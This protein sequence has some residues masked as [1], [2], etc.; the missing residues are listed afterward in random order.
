[1]N[2]ALSEAHQLLV[3]SFDRFFQEMSSM[4][5]GRAHV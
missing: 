2:L 5:I 1:M 4:E 3:D